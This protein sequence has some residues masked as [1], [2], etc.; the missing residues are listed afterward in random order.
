MTLSHL[1]NGKSL[2][3]GIYFSPMIFMTFLLLP[4]FA[5][6][7][8]DHSNIASKRKMSKMFQSVLLM[9]NM[10]FVA[11]RSL[12]KIIKTSL[13]IKEV[14]MTDMAKFDKLN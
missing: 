9:T 8:F 14:V 3:S 1:F 4:H 12:K 6:F 11:T 7:S 2:P 10:Q 5:V 13:V